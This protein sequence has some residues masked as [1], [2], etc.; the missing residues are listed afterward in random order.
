[1]AVGFSPPENVNTVFVAQ[2]ASVAEDKEECEQ[3]SESSSRGV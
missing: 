2:F 1:M 3:T